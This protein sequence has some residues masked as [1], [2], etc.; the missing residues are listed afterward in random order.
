MPFSSIKQSMDNEQSISYDIIPKVDESQVAEWNNLLNNTTSEQ[1]KK[2]KKIA[3]GAKKAEDSIEEYIATC[4]KMDKQASESDYANFIAERMREKAYDK[5]GI[6]DILRQ[7]DELETAVE[8]AR[9]K[10]KNEGGTE[11]LAS[12]EAQIASL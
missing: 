5:Q 9:N 4:I 1:Y 10:F 12:L 8:S 7:Y 2:F 3:D 11:A 6:K